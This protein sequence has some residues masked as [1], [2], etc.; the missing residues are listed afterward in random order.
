MRPWY[1]AIADAQL[2]HPDWS[3]KKIAEFLGRAYQTVLCIVNS[4]TYRMYYAERRSLWNA[5]VTD[6]LQQRL[7]ATAILA[8]DELA[9]RLR[10][11]GMLMK[12]ADVQAIATGA[13][14]AI[15]GP[16]SGAGAP[17]V[18]VNVQQNATPAISVDKSVFEEAQLRIRDD[19]QRLAAESR[20]KVIEAVEVHDAAGSEES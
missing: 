2:A 4:D 20:Q 9:R 3:T 10:D 16:R 12:T 18:H 17:A 11:D 13:I 8:H 19:Q 5:K 1:E 14:D 6:A 15:M 7:F